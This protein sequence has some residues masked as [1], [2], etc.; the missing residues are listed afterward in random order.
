MEYDGQGKVVTIQLDNLIMIKMVKC[1][2]NVSLKKITMDYS[3]RLV[4]KFLAHKSAR[5]TARVWG[6]LSIRWGQGPTPTKLSD[7]L[8]QWTGDCKVRKGT[9]FYYTC[10][11][12]SSHCGCKR[13][14]KVW[15]SL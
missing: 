13:R 15:H 3:P 14:K 4:H 1:R 11:F 7:G 2:S 10:T 5:G 12:V 8:I 9:H 6:A